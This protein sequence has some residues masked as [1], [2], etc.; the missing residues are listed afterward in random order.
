MVIM[1]IKNLK[2]ALLNYYV[3]LQSMVKLLYVV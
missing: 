2:E 3:I 1:I